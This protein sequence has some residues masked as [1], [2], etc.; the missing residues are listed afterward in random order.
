MKTISR[1][2]TPPPDVAASYNAVK[3]YQG[4]RYTGMR[5]GRTHKWYYDRGEWNEKKVTPDQWEIEYAVTKRRAGKAPEGSGVPVG[6]E[7]HW[8]I[9]AHQTVTKLNANDYSTSMSGYKFKLAHKRA[10]QGHWNASANAQRIHLIKIFQ[11]LLRELQQQREGAAGEGSAPA[12]R[13][14]ATRR[15]GKTRR[16]AA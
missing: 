14:G 6:T 13:R 12:K 7:Y 2:K 16:L 11:Q 1:S 4:Q 9:V 5:I 15:H 10:D 3:D 8:Y